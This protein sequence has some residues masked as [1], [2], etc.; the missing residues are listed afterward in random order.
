MIAADSTTGGRLALTDLAYP[1]W[2][3]AVD[4]KDAHPLVIDG[5]FRGIDLSSG[6]H[7]VTWMFCPA[8][9]YWGA[10]IS[11]LA[12][13]ILLAVAHVRFWHPRVFKSPL[14]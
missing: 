11:L 2:S 13:A 10:G 1:G 3:V 9:L 5:T 14:R 8:T 4:G 6:K 7:A 12:M